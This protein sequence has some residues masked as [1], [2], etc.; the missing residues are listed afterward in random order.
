MS[1]KSNLSSA[2]SQIF[3]KPT[4]YSSAFISIHLADA[5][6]LHFLTHKYFN[7]EIYIY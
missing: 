5:G 1:L 3:H 4:H 6:I 2:V 7:S